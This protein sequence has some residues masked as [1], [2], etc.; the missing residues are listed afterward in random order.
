MIDVSHP[1]IY[2]AGLVRQHMSEICLGITAVSLILTGPYINT[3]VQR[4][5]SRMHWLVRFFVFVLICTIGYGFLAQIIYR[6]LKLYLAHQKALP[7]ILIVA[8]IYLLLA[9]FAREQRRI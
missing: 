5:I 4:L 9:F 1:V 2:I 8:F 6:F 7:L 3:L